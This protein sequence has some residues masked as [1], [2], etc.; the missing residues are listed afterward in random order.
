[1]LEKILL[2]RHKSFSDLARE[3]GLSPEF[4][5]L[6]VIGKRK[7]SKLTMRKIADALELPEEVIFP[8]ISKEKEK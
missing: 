2:K 8:D 6:L 4:I 3:T 7:P 5:R 1:M